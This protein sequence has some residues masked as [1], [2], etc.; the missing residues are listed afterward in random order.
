MKTSLAILSVIICFLLWCLYG[1]VGVHV[2]RFITGDNNIDLAK[3]G[4]WG[5]SFGAFNS[6]V[7]MVGS[8]AIVATLLQQSKA[9]AIQERETHKDRFEASFFQLV[10]LLRELRSEITFSHSKDYLANHKPL[11]GRE[12]TGVEAVLAALVESV[13]YHKKLMDTGPLSPKD[14]AKVYYNSVHRRYEYT[15]S[16]Y[17]RLIYTILRKIYSEKSLS[18]TEREQY[19]NIL[20][21]QLTSREL[22]LIAY[23]GMHSVSKDLLGYVSHFHLF[24][25][26]QSN[27]ASR[28]IRGYLPNNAFESRPE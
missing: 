16:P 2:A 15:F 25:Y 4:S 11:I 7:T 22:H 18:V 27:D 8:V 6:L 3:A 14:I 13:W 20:R 1:E 12:Y 23:N 10:S 28:R 24:K 21:S 26:F 9:I 5:D 19:G 17:F